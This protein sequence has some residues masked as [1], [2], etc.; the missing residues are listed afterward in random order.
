MSTYGSII[1]VLAVL[2]SLLVLGTFLFS[3]FEGID[4]F[5]AFY[6]T[7]TVLSTVGFGDIV[8]KTPQSKMLYVVI[9][10]AGIAAYSYF[11]TTVV[12]KLSEARLKN[13]FSQYLP[14]LGEKKNLKDHVIIIGWNRFSEAAYDEL[15]NNGIDVAVVVDDEA[16]AKALAS[17]GVNVVYGDPAT[18]KTLHEAGILGCRAVI[19]TITSL[20][21]LLIYLLKIRGVRGDVQ[22][23]TLSRERKTD[24][25]LKQAGAS[26][27]VDAYDIVG[28]L[29]ASGV[30]EPLA[31]EVLRDMTMAKTGLDLEQLKLSR[32]VSIYELEQEGF[33]SKILLVERG[34]RRLYIPDRDFKLRK[35]DTVVIVGEKERLRFDLKKLEE[36]D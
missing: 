10:F 24:E 4:L 14:G 21:K 16:Q 17:K 13:F 28:R 18:D 30:F 12:S 36:R 27:V 2:G 8:P 32:E 20:E 5:N 7:V 15:E 3:A 29:L 23:I 33:K 9:V 35:G 26:T 25:I 11:V 22:V 31:G 1:T 6:W 19:V 34:G